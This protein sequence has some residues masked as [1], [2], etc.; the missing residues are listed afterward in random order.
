MPYSFPDLTTALIEF[1]RAGLAVTPWLAGMGQAARF[2]P[3][4]FEILDNA[5][6]EYAA[7]HWTEALQY[8]TFGDLPIPERLPRVAMYEILASTAVY[9]AHERAGQIVVDESLAYD[10]IQAVESF[11]EAHGFGLLVTL[12]AVVASYE[13]LSATAYYGG[14][15][16]KE[17]LSGAWH[18]PWIDYSLNDELL[19]GVLMG[20][21]QVVARDG[22]RYV[23]LTA[24]GCEAMARIR[25]LLEQSGYLAKRVRLQHISQFS[26]FQNYE[27]LASVC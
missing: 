21:Y 1:E 3:G 5:A 7:S 24:S 14:I 2:D 19:M 10:I 20:L 27:D 26:L 13:S 17:F 8:E 12:Y 22:R 16:E 25:Q 4:V 15:P 6:R 11:T 9:T 18:R 23:E